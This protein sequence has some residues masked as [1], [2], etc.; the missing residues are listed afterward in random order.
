MK[1][2]VHPFNNLGPVLAD[3]IITF[4]II[5]ELN[6]QTSCGI[7]STEHNIIQL[8]QERLSFKSVKAYTTMPNGFMGNGT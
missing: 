2:Y 7:Y 4:I 3:N 1:Q 6:K 5:N 8:F